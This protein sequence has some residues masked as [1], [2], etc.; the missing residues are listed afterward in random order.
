MLRMSLAEAK[1]HGI[2]PPVPKKTY[3]VTVPLPAGA[4]GATL[5]LNGDKIATKK[6]SP[7]ASAIAEGIAAVPSHMLAD[8]AIWT[9]GPKIMPGQ[10]CSKSNSRQIVTINGRPAIIK[11]KEAREYVK[12]FVRLFFNPGIPFEGNLRMTVTAYYQDRRRDL[13]IA[14]LQDCL[15]EG[16]RTNPGARVIKND[17][18]IIE[19]HAFRKLDKLNPRTVFSL[20]EIKGV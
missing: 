7:R 10:L 1:E 12:T 13:D 3:K 14:L 19:I 20:E 6:L 5:Y 2:I 8:K 17:R 18:Q 4:T 9:Y 15:Q 16:S 11:N